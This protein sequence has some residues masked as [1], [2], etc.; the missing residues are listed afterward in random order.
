MCCVRP[1][2][3][4]GVKFSSSSMLASDHSSSHLWPAERG[5]LAFTC[6]LTAPSR[7]EPRWLP[8]AAAELIY[9]TRR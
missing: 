9:V 6:R 1:L 5:W 3:D 7:A 2:L 4:G 8:F